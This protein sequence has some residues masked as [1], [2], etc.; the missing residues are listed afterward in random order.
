M[1]DITGGYILKIDKS[2]GSGGAGWLSAFP[3]VNMGPNPEFLYEYPDEDDILPVQADYIQNF[4]DSFEIVL[5][6]PSFNNPVT[7]YRSIIDVGTFI[8]YFLVNEISK[9]I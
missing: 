1:I 5:N 2:T 4:I 6:D 9:N 8:D 3:P 7:G